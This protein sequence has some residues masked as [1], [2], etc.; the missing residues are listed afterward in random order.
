RE[1][2]D[3]NALSAHTGTA[4]VTLAGASAA[5]TAPV[6]GGGTTA[7]YTE[8]ADPTAI[9][10]G[11]TVADAQM[12]GFNNGL[13]N[14]NGST[15]TVALGAGASAADSLGFVDGNGLTRVGDQLLKDG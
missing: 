4:V 5:N 6:L 13:G 10:P 3:S 14:Y 12:D 7:G 1:N 15:L 9:A 11:A 2:A 8:Q